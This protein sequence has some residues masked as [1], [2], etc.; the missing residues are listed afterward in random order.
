MTEKLP[1][2]VSADAEHLVNQWCRRKKLTPPDSGFFADF[3]QGLLCHIAEGGDDFTPEV[4]PHDQLAQGLKVLIFNHVRGDAVA[5]DRAYVGD[6]FARHFE[7]TRAVDPHLH[8]IGTMRRPFAPPIN[9]QLNQIIANS[10][11]ELTLVDD[12]IFSGDAIVDVAEML[13]ARGAK[14]STVL[15][16]VAIGEGRRKIEGRG[17]EVVAVVD[18]E[19]VKDEVCERDFLAGIPYS[20][21]TVYTADER[22]YSAP[23]FSPFGDA[24]HWASIDNAHAAR[25]LSSYCLDRSIELWQIIDTANDI[26]ITHPNVPRKLSLQPDD[27][28]IVRYLQDMRDEL[29]AAR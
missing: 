21:R 2:I 24:E 6:D 11:D 28:S 10:G 27:K 12:V 15:A 16:A 20:G 23:Y 18:Y 29:H 5:L 19:S 1:Y 17:I 25:K 22:H 8:G 14:V 13:E 4:L 3:E 26:T 9:D 7:V